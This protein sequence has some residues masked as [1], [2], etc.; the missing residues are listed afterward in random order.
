[1]VKRKTLEITRAEA[2]LAL[3]GVGELLYS[4]EGTDFCKKLEAFLNG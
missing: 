3:K 4:D 2:R 1:M